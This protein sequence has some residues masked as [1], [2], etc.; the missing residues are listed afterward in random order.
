MYDAIDRNTNVII[1]S[2]LDK[3]RA[4]L[5]SSFKRGGDTVVK[6]PGWFSSKFIDV[7]PG[8]RVSEHTYTP[9]VDT[10][11]RAAGKDAGS[12]GGS[13]AKLYEVNGMSLVYSGND[14]YKIVKN[15]KKAK[16][17]NK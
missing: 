15:N 2:S 1:Q 16:K 11:F 10:I 13:N 14:T 6:L 5:P 17:K 8:Q 9:V 3:K 4:E 12:G 7:E